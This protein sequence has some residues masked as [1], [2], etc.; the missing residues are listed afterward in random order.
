MVTKIF[1]INSF[2]K[3]DVNNFKNLSINI[4]KKEIIS[5]F[6]KKKYINFQKRLSINLKKN[7]SLLDIFCLKQNNKIIIKI[8]FIQC[9]LDRAAWKKIDRN[10]K[11]LSYELLK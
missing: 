6:K 8:F 9:L 10:V 1:N 5:I 2:L 7:K 11:H 4:F 3:K